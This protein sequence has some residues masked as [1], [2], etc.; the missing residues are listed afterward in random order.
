MIAD[1]AAVVAFGAF[2]QLDT[3]VGNGSGLQLPGHTLFHV[4][5]GLADLQQSSIGA[6]WM[7]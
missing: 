5:R 3:V 2:V 4:A 1:D 6:S 7:E